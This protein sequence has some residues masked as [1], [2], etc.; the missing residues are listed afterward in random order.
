MYTASSQV[1][2]WAEYCRWFSYD[3]ANA[4]PTANTPIE[5]GELTRIGSQF[6]GEEVYIRSI[7]EIRGTLE[8]MADLTDPANQ[9]FLIMAGFPPDEFLTNRPDDFGLCPELAQI[10]EELGWDALR[11]PSAAWPRGGYTTAIFAAGRSGI[12]SCRAVFT[13]RPT[14]AM[15]AATRYREGQK[16]AWVP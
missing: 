4:A 14:V 11:A 13:G 6:L 8:S 1:V 10:G 15:A 16:P 7:Y 3:I 9:A 5:A 2:A 12:N